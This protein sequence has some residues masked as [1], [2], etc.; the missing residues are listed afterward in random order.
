[1]SLEGVTL[2][3][4]QID[5]EDV[6]NG[7]LGDGGVVDVAVARVRCAKKEVERTVFVDVGSTGVF[8]EAD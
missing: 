6:E 1:M 4:R 7:G 3:G 5:V 8:G 2:R